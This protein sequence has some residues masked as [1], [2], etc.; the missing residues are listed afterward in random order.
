VTRDEAYLKLDP[1]NRLATVHQRHRQTGQ[2][3]QTGQDNGPIGYGEP[4]Y[5]RRRSP[6]NVIAVP[7]EMQNSY[8]RSKLCCL[9]KSGWFF[10]NSN[11][12]LSLLQLKFQISNIAE[13][14]TTDGVHL[15]RADIGF[16]LFSLHQSMALSTELCWN[17][18]HYKFPESGMGC[19]LETCQ[20]ILSPSLVVNNDFLKTG[21]FD[22]LPL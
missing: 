3:G 16:K 11:L 18:L 5:K 4:F 19:V 10:L 13:L 22:W 2:S 6:K 1:S 8:I 9:L 17:S 20:R 14:L 12:F 7:C 21:V 15:L